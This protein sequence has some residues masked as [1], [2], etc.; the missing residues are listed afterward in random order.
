[1]QCVPGYRASAVHGFIARG[2]CVPGAVLELWFGLQAV[3]GL[4]RD[5][6]VGIDSMSLLSRSIMLA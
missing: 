2:D 5:L 6:F 1:M 4:Q 3:A